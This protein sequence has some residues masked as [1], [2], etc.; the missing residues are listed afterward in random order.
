MNVRSHAALVAVAMLLIA[1]L[2]ACTD[3][4]EGE[5]VEIA[6]T[7]EVVDWVVVGEGA[8]AEVVEVWGY[9]GQY[10]GPLIEAT[11]GDTLRV[12]LTNQLPEGTTIHWHGLEV[13]NDQDGVP[14]ITQPL[15]EP[16]ESYTYQF[17]LAKAG[18]TMYHTHAN[19]VRQ[20]SRGLIGPLVVHE[21]SAAARARYD[22]DYTMVL[23]EIGGLFTI[24][25][26]AFPATLDHDDTFIHMKTGD[27]VRVRFINAGQVSHP[28]HLHGHQFRVI[29][30]DSN[31]L[32]NPY[33]ANTVDVA[34]GQ[35]VDV[36]IVGDN[37]GTW[38]LH[39]H[40]LPHV[41]NRGVYPGG[42]LTLVDYTD[43]TSM[44]EG[45][46]VPAQPP[47]VGATTAAPAATAAPPRAAATPP[48]AAATAAEVT[49]VGTEFA[50]AP[51]AVSAPAGSQVRIIL[52]N[53]GGIAHDI[54][55]PDLE[56]VVYADPG[57]QGGVTVT[58]PNEP[59]R[60]YTFYCAIP[61][62]RELGMEG[63]LR[64]E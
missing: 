5:L 42:M 28:M 57:E 59:G 58:L 12:T 39:C 2:V 46:P 20:L 9:N 51:E 49:V 6:L 8:D 61:G 3:P 41:T 43:H 33:L 14:G 50:F 13:P 11:E 31:R 34:P 27:H 17:K 53:E 38:T 23:H 22:L 32:K 37:P 30:L 63:V 54:T 19:T 60:E 45:A 55:I 48:A 16:G 1:S 24:N 26:H 25:G 44:L 4:R 52:D 18:T 40:I 7:A 47:A 10:P 36:E 56:V 21:R 64:I 35:T 15:I 29:E 62:H